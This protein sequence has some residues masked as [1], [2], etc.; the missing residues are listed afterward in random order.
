MKALRF[1][2][3]REDT[4]GTST[5]S[6]SVTSLPFAANLQYLVVKGGCIHLSPLK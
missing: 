1:A 2:S 4:I 5:I 6:L 3:E